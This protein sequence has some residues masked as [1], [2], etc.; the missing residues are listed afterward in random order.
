MTK[1]ETV[2]RYVACAVAGV[3]ALIALDVTAVGLGIGW[4]AWLIDVAFFSG[5]IIVTIG[6]RLS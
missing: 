6:C 3:G 5:L 2:V 1:R 4:A